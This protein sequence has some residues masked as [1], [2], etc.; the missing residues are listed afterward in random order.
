MLMGARRLAVLGTRAAVC[1]I[2]VSFL[3]LPGIVLAQDADQGQETFQT[4][5]S[6]CHTIGGGRVLGPDLQGIAER[7]SEQWIIDFVQQSQ[8]LVQAGDA[9]AVA[10]FKEYG[11]FPMPDQA[12]SDD[13]VREI[14]A[15]I[16]SFAGTEAAGTEAAGTETAA[17]PPATAPPATDEQVALGAELFQGKAGLANGGPSCMS[18]HD[19]RS[20]DGAGGGSLAIDLTDAV[21]RLTVPGIGAVLRNPPFPVMQRAYADHPLTDPEVEA[22]VGFLQNADAEQELYEARAYGMQFLLAGVAGA[23]FL[24]G[25]YT[26]TWRGRRKGTVYQVEFDRQVKST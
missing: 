6:M 10:V 3:S 18:C 9:D 1:T 11:G 15:H 5:C 8:D 12:L 20:E 14:L 4:M 7:R 22:L 2:L 16:G 21:T 24:L 13:E 17:P 19:V 26:L 25:L 23:I